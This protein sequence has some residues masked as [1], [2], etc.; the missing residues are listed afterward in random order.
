MVLKKLKE[1]GKLDEYL[2]KDPNFM[3]SLLSDPRMAKEDVVGLVT[4]LFG[5]GID[6]VIIITNAYSFIFVGNNF[7]G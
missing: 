6:S 7:R 4:S 3:H 1:D 5:G 2:S